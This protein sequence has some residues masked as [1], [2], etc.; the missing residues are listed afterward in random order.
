MLLPPVNVYLDL[1]IPQNV[2]QFHIFLKAFLD[3]T[4]QN[5]SPTFQYFHRIQKLN[6]SPHVFLNFI[7][8]LKGRNCIPF[9]FVFSI[10]TNPML[11]SEKGLLNDYLLFVEI[12]STHWIQVCF[13]K[14]H[15]L[16]LIPLNDVP[17]KTH[18]SYLPTETFPSFVNASFN[19]VVFR[20]FTIL[21]ILL[22][23]TILFQLLPL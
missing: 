14:L 6:Q 9:I 23:E 7:V 20:F 5:W 22:L 4:G 18:L 13:L 12:C 19:D 2:T 21:P 10:S 8:L 1:L 16:N 3:L 11:Y 15:R 17:L